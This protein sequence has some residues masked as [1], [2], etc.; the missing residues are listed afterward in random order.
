MDVR[1]LLWWY[2]QKLNDRR[3][4]QPESVYGTIF[5]ALAKLEGGAPFM[6][7]HTEVILNH[8]PITSAQHRDILTWLDEHANQP[9]QS[10]EYRETFIETARCLRSGSHTLLRRTKE[11]TEMNES[12]IKNLFATL[13][14]RLTTVNL[15]NPLVLLAI[16][17]LA[18]TLLSDEEQERIKGKAAGVLDKAKALA[19]LVRA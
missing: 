15:Q 12:E 3:D 11:E 18:F 7:P 5:R 8:G 4:P 14:D 16:G 17:Y 9:G 1:P 2:G 10:R 19:T 13:T 6:G